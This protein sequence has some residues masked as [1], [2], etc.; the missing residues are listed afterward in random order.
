[1]PPKEKKT[2]KPKKP[3]TTRRRKRRTITQITQLPQ[4]TG[5]NRDI[6][7]GGSGGSSN[8]L[9]S[10]VANR[11]PS[12]PPTTPIQTPDAFRVAQEQNRQAQV[13]QQVVEEVEKEKRG[14]RTDAEIAEQL[15]MSVEQYRMER[16]A[17]KMASTMPLVQTPLSQIAGRETETLVEV[18][19]RSRERVAFATPSSSIKKATR[20]RKATQPD[21][22]EIMIEPQP[23]VAPVIGTGT[24]YPGGVPVNQQGLNMAAAGRLRGSPPEDAEFGEDTDVTVFLG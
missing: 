9:A 15:G 19:S 11:P 10:I 22:A 6:P 3:T 14:R 2:K 8:L 7:M 5:L 18:R 12:M 21:D 24:T 13:L 17:R 20:G 1:M 16:R 23:T 4:F